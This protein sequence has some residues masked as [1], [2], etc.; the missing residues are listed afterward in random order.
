MHTLATNLNA[1][2]KVTVIALILGAGLPLIFAY[3]IK[4]WSA[5]TTNADGTSTGQRNSAAAAGAI[6][7]FGVVVVAV[8][9]GILYIA[10]AFIA[11]K[12][13]IHLF[14]A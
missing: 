7:C 1:L 8:V 12:F 11:S 4:F 3:G 5:E 9:A 14:G 10:K 13:D 6:A 2:W